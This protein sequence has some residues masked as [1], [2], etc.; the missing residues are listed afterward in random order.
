MKYSFMTFST[1]T[2]D[3]QEVLK[4]ARRYGYDGIE[5]RLDS[6]HRHGVEVEATPARRIAI[7]DNVLRSGIHMCCLATSLRYADPAQTDDV[8]EQTHERIDLAGDLEVSRMRVFGGILGEGLDREQAI[9]LVAKSL[10]KVADHA[11]ERGVTLCMETHDAW[12][13]PKNVAAVLSR[14]S[15]PAIACNWDIMHPV[16]THEATI[17]E[18]FSCLQQW[19][20]HVHAH[21]GVGENVKLVP[22]GEGEIDHKR[23]IELLLDADY[24]G[25]ISGE[26]INWEPYETHLPRELATLK[27]Y[28][29]EAQ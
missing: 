26:W 16:R 11:A 6:G 4:T 12:C 5:P 15:H 29:Q 1:P 27:R 25:Y 28:Q 18:S 7:R 14:V 24:S 23:T 13:D 9:D 10:G 17:D 20:R 3:L 8:I 21:D 19:I 2:L 22:I